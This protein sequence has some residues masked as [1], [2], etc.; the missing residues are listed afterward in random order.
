MN[1][2]LI[3]DEE[4]LRQFYEWAGY[5]GIEKRDQVLFLS[6]SARAKHLT[7]EE[8]ET[9]KLG[10][11]E[12]FRREIVHDFNYPVFLRT[13]K[14]YEVAEEVYTTKNGYPIP[15][16]CLSVYFNINPSSMIKAYYDFQNDMNRRLK[17]RL[18]SD[19]KDLT[20]FYKGIGKADTL[21]KNY[22]QK[23]RG[24]KLF[25][26]FDFDIADHVM[27]KEKVW[28][29]TIYPQFCE[30]LVNA[31]CRVGKIVT[32]NGFHVMIDVKSMEGCGKE[33]NPY[34][35]ADGVRLNDEGDLSEAVY[36]K[37]HMIPLPGTGVIRFE[38]VK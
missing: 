10:R 2:N 14:Q 13:V 35:L 24:D 16:K 20:D 15:E 26:D 23:S 21:L 25:I 9:I 36:N 27:D 38:E 1:Y 3:T 7:Q 22:I 17:E 29:H 12:M 28:K 5:E 18:T 11:A 8:R 34:F 19:V 32:R 33:N 6:L 4:N 37:N 31:G 30:I